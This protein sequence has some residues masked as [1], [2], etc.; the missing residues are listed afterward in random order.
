MNKFIIPVAILSMLAGVSYTGDDKKN[1]L[2]FS[3]LWK[4]D[5]KGPIEGIFSSLAQ[6]QLS[7][8]M[9]TR[10]NAIES[11]E[12]VLIVSEIFDGTSDPWISADGSMDPRAARLKSEIA[13]W[14]QS[15]LSPQTKLNI[16]YYVAIFL[17]NAGTTADPLPPAATTMLQ[18]LRNVETQLNNIVGVNAALSAQRDGAVLHSAWLLSRALGIPEKSALLEKIESEIGYWQAKPLSAPAKIWVISNIAHLLSRQNSVDVVA[19]PLGEFQ[20]IESKTSSL[21]T[22]DAALGTKRDTILEKVA[23]ALSSQPPAQMHGQ[24]ISINTGVDSIMQGAN[25][26]QN[27]MNAIDSL[28]TQRLAGETGPQPSEAEI[29]F[30]QVREEVRRIAPSPSGN[31]A[32]LNNLIEKQLCTLAPEAGMCTTPAD[33]PTLVSPEKR[34]QLLQSIHDQV[35]TLVPPGS[36]SKNQEEVIG[37][38]KQVEGLVSGSLTSEANQAATDVR[39]K[40]NSVRST[41]STIAGNDLEGT[42]DKLAE[43]V[44]AIGRLEL[45]SHIPRW[46]PQM[47]AGIDELYSETNSIA[48]STTTPI[49]KLGNILTKAES[50]FPPGANSSYQRCAIAHFKSVAKLDLDRLIFDG[51]A[52]SKTPSEPGTK[53]ESI[54]RDDIRRKIEGMAISESSLTAESERLLTLKLHMDG[55]IDS[56]DLFSKSP[57][58]RELKLSSTLNQIEAIAR[59]KC[60][61]GSLEGQ[62]LAPIRNGIIQALNEIA[63]T[64]AED[65]TK[66][67]DDIKAPLNDAVDNP[68]KYGEYEDIECRLATILHFANS[69]KERTNMTRKGKIEAIRGMVE[70]VMKA[71]DAGGWSSVSTVFAASSSPTAESIKTMTAGVLGTRAQEVVESALGWFSKLGLAGEETREAVEGTPDETRQ[72]SI[73]GAVEAVGGL[74]QGFGNQ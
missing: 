70:E 4:N 42:K 73:E 32:W 63:P 49:V 11:A 59:G 7:A 28:V 38:L 47:Q 14:Q 60:V 31:A 67:L 51:K 40:L 1:L 55:I 2:E 74:L 35:I 33:C 44:S 12:G 43:V 8:A 20:A 25:T 69:V 26:A 72:K 45:D 64:P 5:I 29:A 66:I 3:D 18:K 22:G 61:L 58:S 15:S 36:E 34:T 6:D 23:S 68:S 57:T 50:A 30:S 53:S 13:H 37:H 71:K 39:A 48:G 65:E 41:A 17:K 10:D 24:L 27:K 62:G 52:P 9:Q 21:A 54:L 56:I 46:A 16:I 19:G